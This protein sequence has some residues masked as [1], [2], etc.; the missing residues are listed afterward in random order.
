MKKK[1]VLVLLAAGDSRRFGSNK[2][3]SDVNGIPMYRHLAGQIDELAADTFYQKILVTQYQEIADDLGACGYEVV[4]NHKSIL[5][6]SHSI[7]LALDQM[8]DQADAACFAVC[9]QP[10]LQGQTIRAFLQEWEDS[11]KGI[12]CLAYAGRLGNPAVYSRA[13]F[14]ELY[15]IQGD[16]GGKQILKKYIDDVYL[17]QV[18]DQKELVDID[19]NACHKDID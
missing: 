1:I 5:G 9:D 15:A 12:G 6:I 10:W 4:I 17:Y 14:T 13:Y 2:L 11:N 19:K 18:E 16:V 3:L 7:H 8:D